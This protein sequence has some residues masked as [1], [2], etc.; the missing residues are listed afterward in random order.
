MQFFVRGSCTMIDAAV[1]C[2]VDGI[3]KR[4]HY[5]STAADLVILEQ[6]KTKIKASDTAG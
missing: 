3:A 5:V 6:A 4:S 1:Q 2:D